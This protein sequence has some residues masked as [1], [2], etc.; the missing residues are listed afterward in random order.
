MLMAA[1]LLAHVQ[2][3][4]VISSVLALGVAFIAAAMPVSRLAALLFLPYVVWL[5]YATALNYS[6]V[7][8]NGCALHAR[9]STGF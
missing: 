8:L 9:N 1:P 3:L 2:A 7:C 4:V 5:A 6:I